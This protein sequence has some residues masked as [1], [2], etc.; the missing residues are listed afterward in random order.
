MKPDPIFPP[1]ENKDAL[2]MAILPHSSIF[3]PV[4]PIEPEIFNFLTP[5]HGSDWPPCSPYTHF[6]SVETVHSS[7]MLVSAHR[8][9]WYNSP[10]HSLNKTVFRPF[11]KALTT[12]MDHLLDILKSVYTVAKFVYALCI[13]CKLIG[14]S[15]HVSSP[16]LLNLVPRIYNRS[17]QI[18]LILVLV[19][20][21]C[22]WYMTRGVHLIRAVLIYNL[23]LCS[24]SQTEGY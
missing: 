11:F 23:F 24:C 2:K 8:T 18:N 22:N 10:D 6:N 12:P 20:A 21:I 17:S 16:K 3:L 9:A 5:F 14:V 1:V 7:E 13:H 15:V 19:S 4:T